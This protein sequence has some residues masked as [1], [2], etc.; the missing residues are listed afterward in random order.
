M[1]LLMASRKLPKFGVKRRRGLLSAFIESADHLDSRVGQQV[2]QFLMASRKFL[3]FG[4]KRRRGLLPAFIEG[5]HHVDGVFRQRIMQPLMAG[6]K[7]RVNSAGQ[8]V[9]AVSSFLRARDSDLFDGAD[10]FVEN[11]GD[12]SGSLVQLAHQ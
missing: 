10:L 1:Q 2:V 7:A 12:A 9:D 3:K 11:V 8:S 5:A 4:V 6:R